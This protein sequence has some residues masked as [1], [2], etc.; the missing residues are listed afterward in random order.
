MKEPKSFC[1]RSIFCGLALSFLL[2]FHSTC[3][4]D[5]SLL[6]LGL[7]HPVTCKDRGRSTIKERTVVHERECG[8][9]ALLHDHGLGII[10][11]GENLA[12]TIARTIFGPVGSREKRKGKI[13]GKFVEPARGCK[14]SLLCFWAN[15][16]NK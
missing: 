11:V 16:A 1:C 8:C 6:L 9:R 7:K 5:S 10:V 2:S 3:E 13:T 15:R 14:I 4:S 12:I